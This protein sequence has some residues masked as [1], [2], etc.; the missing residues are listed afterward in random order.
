VPD[1][2]GQGGGAVVGHDGGDGND[3]LQD[4]TIP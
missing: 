4:G 1:G 3:I 2:A